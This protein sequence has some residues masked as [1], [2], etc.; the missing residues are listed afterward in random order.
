MNA[1]ESW[2]ELESPRKYNFSFI[3]DQWHILSKQMSI[4]DNNYN[5]VSDFDE[6]YDPTHLLSSI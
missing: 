6:D 3:L 2:K 5:T 4:K 1:H